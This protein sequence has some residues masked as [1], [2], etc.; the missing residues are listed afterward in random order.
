MVAC[1]SING[2]AE[3]LHVIHL[4]FR[5]EV[6]FNEMVDSELKPCNANNCGQLSFPRGSQGWLALGD[7]QRLV[8]R[9]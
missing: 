8:S 3:A 9:N 5:E 4:V 1:P 7:V 2:G 6:P